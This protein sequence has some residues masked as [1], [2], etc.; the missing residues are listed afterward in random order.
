MPDISAE[1][2]QAVIT[3][4]VAR[5]TQ[6]GVTS[7]VAVVD[8]GCHLKAF[9]RM[10]GALLGSADVAIKKARTSGLFNLSTDEL[11][12]ADAAGSAALRHRGHQRRVGHVRWWDAH[13]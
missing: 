4:V 11:A 12:K 7:N 2:A 1:A 5:A 13:L 9:L 3:A 8:S 10:N 6:M